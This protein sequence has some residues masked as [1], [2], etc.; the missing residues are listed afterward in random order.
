MIY[1]GIFTSLTYKESLSELPKEYIVEMVYRYDDSL[2]VTGS[3]VT[4][5]HFLMYKIA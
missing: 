1:N 3:F 5:L 4:E 2:I